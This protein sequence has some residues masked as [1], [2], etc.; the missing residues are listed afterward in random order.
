MASNPELTPEVLDELHAVLLSE[1]Q[2]LRMDI[3]D[4]RRSETNAAAGPVDESE[5]ALPGDAAD[6]SVDLQGEDDTQEL[7][8][9]LDTHLAEVDHALAKFE[10][11]TYGVC[12]QCDLPIPVGRL[13]ILPE[14]RYDVE[15]QAE[16]ETGR[17]GAPIIADHD[18]HSTD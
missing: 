3:T 12:E 2:R 6:D 11:G 18:A 13:R 1:Q 17:V 7:L 5:D 8:L 9:D 10:A 4:L 16:H 15:H 14:A